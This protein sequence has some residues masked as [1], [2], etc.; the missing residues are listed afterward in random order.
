MFPPKRRDEILKDINSKPRFK[1]AL[2]RSLTGARYFNQLNYNT[3]QHT[4]CKELFM[5]FPVVIYVPKDFYLTSALNKVLL[6]LQAA[7]LI[8]YWHSQIIDERFV[9]VQESKQPKGIKLAYLSGCF[10]IW[11]I[12]CSVS[13]ITFVCEIVTSKMR[14]S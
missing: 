11:I 6:R 9:K 13:F 10:Y 2:L 3:T 12:S 14:K 4:L 1:G 8:H 5:M 7:G